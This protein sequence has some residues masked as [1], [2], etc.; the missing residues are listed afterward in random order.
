M[1]NYGIVKSNERPQ[2][3]EITASKV[4]LASDI[5]QYTEEIEPGQVVSGYQYNYIE[6]TKDE[7]LS[8]ITEENA[9]TIKQLQEE[10]QA[11]KILLGVE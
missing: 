8:H 5:L 6:Y 7:Y 1:V 11:T 9:Q 2:E 4:F 3:I 10:L